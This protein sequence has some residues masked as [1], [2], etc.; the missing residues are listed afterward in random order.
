MAIDIAQ[1]KAL[2][3]IPTGDGGDALL[4]DATLQAI[5]DLNGDVYLAAAG[6]CRRIA[7]SLPERTDI[8]ASGSE[9]KRSQEF[10]HWIALAMD[11]EKRARDNSGDTPAPIANGLNN[12]PAFVEGQFNN[13]DGESND[14][15][16]PAER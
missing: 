14:P 3:A 6:I 13:P 2:V 9:V 15:A 11:F 4:D 1:L 5:A 7:S 10:E 8:K 16:I 12:S